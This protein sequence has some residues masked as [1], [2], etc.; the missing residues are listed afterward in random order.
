ML[1]ET[2]KTLYTQNA[3]RKE[4]EPT[5]NRIVIEKPVPL[6]DSFYL[7]WV[8]G[9]WF[10]IPMPFDEIFLNVKPTCPF[11]LISVR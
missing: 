7:F 8:F 9:F 5:P 3:E 1:H 2:D 10:S 4:E 6:P 11:L